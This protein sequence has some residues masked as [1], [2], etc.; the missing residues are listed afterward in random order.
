VP[1]PPPQP[2]R[3]T[4]RTEEVI[5]ESVRVSRLRRVRLV[6]NRDV[7]NP[8]ASSSDQPTTST[9]SA[10]AYSNLAPFEPTEPAAPNAIRTP[11]LPWHYSLHVP[12]R[13]ACENGGTAADAGGGPES[14]FRNRRRLSH[15]VAEPNVGRGYIKEIS[16]G[17]GGRIIASPFGYGV[18]LLAFDPDCSELCD[19]TADFATSPV[20]LHEVVTN[21][22]HGSVV[23]C[24][25][26]SP[27]SSLLVT[28]SLGGKVAFH[29]PR[30]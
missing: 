27:D 24:T 30:W 15:F 28:G 1:P 12:E 16:F 23:V 17:V 21:I 25:K 4:E 8:D 3:Q 29:R 6:I 9:S 26:F 2:L 11:V 13:S 10:A 20:Q 14:V 22:C 5:S 18:R 19:R 7:V